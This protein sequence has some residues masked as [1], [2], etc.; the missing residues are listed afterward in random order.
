MD[1]E[2]KREL[3]EDLDR[4]VESRE[5]YRR[6]GKAW[7]RGYLFHGP[8]GTGKSSLVAAMAN[9]LRFDVYDLDLKEVQCNS[10][11]RRL[12]IGTGNRS[13]LV[14]EDI[15]RSFESVE[16][17]EVI[18]MPFFTWMSEFEYDIYKKWGISRVATL[19]LVV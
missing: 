15:D 9:Y 5:F 8:P 19:R 3:I 11:L 16:D 6:V 13:M 18:S 1:P 4:F 12:L 2:M 10:D 17:D 14:I 7:K